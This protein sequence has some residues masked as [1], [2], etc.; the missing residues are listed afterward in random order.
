M[1]WRDFQALQDI[2][3]LEE[4][5]VSYVD[6]GEGDPVVLLHG[7]PTWGYL[8]Q[9]LWP[10]LAKRHRILIPDL[11]GFGF[12]DKRDRFD[13]SIDRQTDMIVSWL[14]K[15]GVD[16]TTVVGHDIG[17]GV[18]L[19]LATLHSSRVQKLCL[20]NSV[21]YDS[22]PIEAMLQFGHPEV[23]RKIS[24][25]TAGIMLKQALKLGCATALPDE[26]LEGWLAPY[27]TEV[28]KRSLIRNAAALNTNLTMELTPLLPTMS[29]R[30]LIIWGED[31]RFQL[32]RYGERLARDLPHAQLHRIHDARHFVMYDQ[33]EKVLGLVSNFLDAGR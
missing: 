1:S 14:D 3:E 25:A 20:L 29:V 22:G 2:C 21:C 26:V 9:P 10:P 6:Q 5:F 13:R 33:A 30:T 32:V 17:G 15:L 12:S 8:W 28:G 19:R 27:S 18:A 4:R 23:R 11:L 7:I 24:A 16:R 31:D